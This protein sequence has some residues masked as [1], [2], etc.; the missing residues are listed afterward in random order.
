MQN[1]EQGIKIV[2]TG[3]DF[4]E[5]WIKHTC[6]LSL[7]HF[8]NLKRVLKLSIIGVIDWGRG[9]YEING[10][11]HNRG[12]VGDIVQKFGIVRFEF[13]DKLRDNEELEEFGFRL[14]EL[15][16]LFGRGLSVPRSGHL[17]F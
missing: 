3:R 4:L 2:R 15:L 10:L 13:L 16:Q 17:V 5:K 6:G 1:V 11:A 12:I 14:D 9:D 7:N 8:N